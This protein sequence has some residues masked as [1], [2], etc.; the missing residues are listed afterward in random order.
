MR[1]RPELVEIIRQLRQEHRGFIDD[2]TIRHV[3]A[4]VRAEVSEADLPAVLEAAFG[5]NPD[6][7]TSSTQR[8]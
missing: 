6:G 5:R 7:S 8:G 4:E 1:L 2:D 3:L